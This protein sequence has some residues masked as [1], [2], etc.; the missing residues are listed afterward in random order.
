MKRA[1]PYRMA[2]KFPGSKYGYSAIPRDATT[3]AN[4]GE[5]WRKA[6]DDQKAAR[7]AAR[8][9][10]RGLYT[11]NPSAMLG[12][13]VL[14]DGMDSKPTFEN[15]ADEMGAIMITHHEYIKDIYGSLS[16]GFANE[17]FNVN[18][19]LEATFPWLAQV[20]A[21]FEEYEFVQCLFEYRSTLGDSAQT[22]NGQV[23]QIMMAPNYNV[24]QPIWTDKLSFLTSPS[25]ISGK[26]TQS[27]T[28]GLECKHSV[29]AGSRI[30]YIRT[31]PVFVDEDI[32][33]YD[34]A[35]LQ[36][37]QLGIPSEFYGQQM[38]ELWVTY[39]V[40]LRKPKL[41]SGV[42]N[43]IS[44][45]QFCANIDGGYQLWSGQQ[46]SIGTLFTQSGNTFTLTFPS[47]ACAYYEIT[48]QVSFVSPEVWEGSP[49]ISVTGEVDL[50]SDLMQQNGAVSY[51]LQPDFSGTSTIT[52]AT[53][54]MHVRVNTGTGGVLNTVEYDYDMATLSRVI[55]TVKEY[56]T[57]NGVGSLPIFLKNGVQ[58]I[59]FD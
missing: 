28:A 30:K 59:P 21:N 29:N 8:Y 45:D 6:S 43:T 57:M 51:K 36:V 9:F 32:K 26:T 39:S 38:G 58:S 7:T 25:P 34:L 1:T 41:N 40:I 35:K 49:S 20:A 48:S 4:Y 44:T 19:G 12:N 54:V 42:G 33:T 17:E 53:S 18:P 22:T 31:S 16:S 3:L 11:R 14:A 23:G 37:A 52:A 2:R 24:G 46:N 13:N 10:G 50:V 56:N 15:V 5:T 55:I 27:I 47:S